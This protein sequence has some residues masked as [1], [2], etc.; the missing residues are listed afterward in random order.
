MKLIQ[1]RD[2]AF[3]KSL[4]RLAESGRERKKTGQ[5]LL[6]GLHLVESY[7]MACG[8]LET[9]VLGESALASDELA[10]YVQGRDHVVITDVLMRDIGLVETPAVCWLWQRCPNRMLRST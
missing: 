7:E 9:L 5:T 10:A 4:K 6:D 2:N 8:P 3:F 1:S